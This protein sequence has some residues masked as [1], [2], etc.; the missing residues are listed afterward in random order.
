[1]AQVRAGVGSGR[2]SLRDRIVGY[3]E[4]GKGRVCG[5]VGGEAAC[6]GQSLDLVPVRLGRMVYDCASS[7]QEVEAE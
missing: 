7:T 2:G 3:W 5:S 1:M 6:F 4:P